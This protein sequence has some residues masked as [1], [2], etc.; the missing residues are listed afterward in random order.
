MSCA[1]PI[2]TPAVSVVTPRGRQRWDG[3]T[4]LLWALAAALLLALAPH[5]GS[6]WDE[7]VRANAGE[8]KLRYYAALFA[9][10]AERAAANRNPNDRYP[11]FHDLSLALIQGVSPFTPLSTGNLFS[12]ALGLLTLAAA[13]AIARR[14]AGPEA[15]FWTLLLLL[16]YPRFTG[17]LPINP[18]DVPFA[19]GYTLSLLCL[20]GWFRNH[21]PSR[22]WALATGMAIGCAMAARIGGMLLLCYLAAFLCLFAA[23]NLWNAHCNNSALALNHLR[24]A[25]R[26]RAF[27]PWIVAIALTTV[28][29][30]AILFAFFPALHANPFAHAGKTLSAVTHFDWQMPIFFKGVLGTTA[31]LPRWYSLHMF[32]ITAPLPFLAALAAASLL[33]ARALATCLCHRQPIPLPTLQT[34]ALHFTWLFP[35][36][37]VIARHSTLYNGTRHLLFIIPPAAACGGIAL[38][39]LHALLRAHKPHLRMPALAALALAFGMVLIPMLRLHPYQYIY[40]N[41]CVGGTANAA[42]RYETDYWGTAYRELA[43]QFHKALRTDPQ[44]FPPPPIVVNTEHVRHLLQP[45]LEAGTPV[46]VILTRA[47]PQAAH[48]HAASTLWF[49]HF[50]YEGQPVAAVQRMGIPLAW[51]IDLRAIPP[52]YRTLGFFPFDSQATLQSLNAAD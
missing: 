1:A 14:I 27:V 45:F 50:F 18:K 44:R 3:A 33:T 16:L 20:L 31:D 7:E 32:A 6:S 28:T 12:T 11:G 34:L 25:L 38:S 52:E 9:G 4:V 17:H 26:R 5:Y 41:E 13:A 47:Q 19:F 29:A 36:A 48:F 22:R 15:A 2:S 21:A 37:Y 40:Y 10:D 24:A 46:P 30:I 42:L 51:L 43:Q 49:A 35:L 8:Q 39:Q 23:A